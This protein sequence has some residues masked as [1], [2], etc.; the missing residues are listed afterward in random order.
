MALAYTRHRKSDTAFKR[1]E[2]QRQVIQGIAK[3][4]VAPSGW[5]YVPQVY[6]YSKQHMDIAVNPIKAL[7][8]LPAFLMHQSNIDQ[9]EITGDGKLINGIWYFMPDEASLEQA[10]EEFKN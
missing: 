6:N 7:S 3:K 2:R 8:V 9:Y 5:K 10:R 1:D 4:L